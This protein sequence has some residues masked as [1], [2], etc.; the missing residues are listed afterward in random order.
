MI[1]K[2]FRYEPLNQASYLVGCPK[3]KEAIVIDPIED[4]GVD[5][6]ILEAADLGLAITGVAET[7]VHADYISCARQ[8]A[9][10]ADCPHYLHEAAPVTY[11]FTPIRDG[12][13]LEV[14]QVQIG[15]VHT[16][17]HTPEH[18]SYVV[19]DKSRSDEPWAVLTGDSL[20]VGD[21]GRPDLLIGDQALDVMDEGE[22]AETQFRTIRERLFTLPDHVEVF[23][24]HYGGSLCGGVNM[25]GKVSSTI[26]FEKNYNLA[27]Q[28]ADA[29]AFATFVQ[30]TAKPLPDDYQR[31]KSY[32]LGLIDEE[33]LSGAGV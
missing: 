13:V 31:I 5:F 15:V 27:M 6:Y 7:H 14:G 3:A 32:N 2:Q 22:R 17:G 16:P 9:E 28:K 11:D 33:E 4:L 20:F 18:T 26:Y 21:V 19:T 10:D 29:E 24:N 25:S 1:F 23:P 12:D 8:L 30:E